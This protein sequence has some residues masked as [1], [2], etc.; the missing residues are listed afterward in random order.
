MRLI[1]FLVFIISLCFSGSIRTQAQSVVAGSMQ[2]E[3]GKPIQYAS[4][5][6]LK[7]V[8]SS[9]VKGA[10]SDAAG[11]YS[12]HNISQGKYFVSSTH[13]GMGQVYSKIIE[14]TS[15]EKQ[16]NAGILILGTTPEQLNDVTINGKRP[17]FEQQVDRMVINVK[18]SIV[19]AGGT[20]LDV[21]E[22]SPGVTVNRQNNSIAV[23]GKNGVVVMLNGKM[24]YMPMDALVQMLAGISAGNIDKIELITTP[25]SKY[26]AEGNAGYINIVLISNPYQGLNGSYFLTAGY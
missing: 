4:V 26:D 13:T 25:P 21:L 7:T 19:N 9:L 22:K 16:I 10:M 6:L 8:D 14:V 17:M 24:T 20:A 11:K 15:G 2:D 23:N 1:S 3:K 18:N 12:F 5:H